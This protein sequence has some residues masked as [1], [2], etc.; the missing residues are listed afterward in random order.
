MAQSEGASHA[1]TSGLAFG[2]VLRH[3][4]SDQKPFGPS[5]HLN[6]P[7]LVQVADSGWK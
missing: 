2:Q 7:K 6:E 1:V 5:G 3:A 4:S